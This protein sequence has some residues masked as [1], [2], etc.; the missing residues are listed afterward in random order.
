M[1]TAKIPMTGTLGAK[2]DKGEPGERGL[3]GLPGATGQTGSQGPK[4]DTGDTGATGQTGAQ[5]NPGSDASVTKSNVEAVLTGAIT[6]HTHGYQRLGF[7]A[8]SNDTTAQELNTYIN[9]RVTVTANR[10]LTTTVL[11]A[12]EV[13]SVTILTSGTTSYTVTFGSGF[14]PVG[15]LA[16]GTAT[17]KKFQISFKS[18]GTNMIEMCRTA[19]LTA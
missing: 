19:A 7:Q 11:P 2:G 14:K 6:T 9:T 15:T 16:T 4:G 12:G 3:Q 5:G 10:T 8:L 1:P 13:G 18:D 17:A